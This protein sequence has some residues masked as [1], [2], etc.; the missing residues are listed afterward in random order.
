VD[1][2]P[3]RPGEVIGVAPTA[4]THRSFSRPHPHTLS[5]ARSC[6]DVERSSQAASYL[7]LRR[8]RRKRPNSTAAQTRTA[9]PK[10]GKVPTAN[11]PVM[12]I[13]LSASPIS[14]PATTHGWVD[15]SSSRHPPSEATADERSTVMIGNT[16]IST[17][18][19]I[20]LRNPRIIIPPDSSS[21]VCH[22]ELAP[23]VNFGTRMHTCG[24][25]KAPLAFRT[26]MVSAH[27]SG[28]GACPQ[29]G[30]MRWRIRRA[31]LCSCPLD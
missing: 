7:L 1:A 23:V 6:S 17:M 22:L 16:Q 13:A 18:A 8:A 5:G 31:G 3:I 28:G 2:P 30:G 24:F 29:L 9:I 10:R 15:A 20:S 25:A 27:H 19:I 4:P 11:Q 14:T 26:A 12:N 21:S